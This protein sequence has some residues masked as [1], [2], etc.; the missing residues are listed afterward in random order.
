M[1]YSDDGYSTG[2]DKTSPGSSLLGEEATGEGQQRAGGQERAGGQQRAG[3][4][5]EGQ[6]GPVRGQSAGP[7]GAVQGSGGP[8]L[9]ILPLQRRSSPQEDF[10]WSLQVQW[11]VWCL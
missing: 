1:L 3:G 7:G 11:P 9:A 4:Q 5:T 2:G 8:C 10:L 6:E